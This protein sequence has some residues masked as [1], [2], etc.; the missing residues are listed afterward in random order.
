M[1]KTFKKKKKCKSFKVVNFFYLKPSIS[2]F[3]VL[4][5]SHFGG[6][7]NLI[8]VIKSSFKDLTG[9]HLKLANS[10]LTFQGVEGFETWGSSHGS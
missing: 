9:F 5:S 10:S 1:Q 4:E 8:T 7:A 2:G 3:A 6:K